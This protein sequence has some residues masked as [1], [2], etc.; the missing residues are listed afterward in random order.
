MDHAKVPNGKLTPQSQTVWDYLKTGRSLTNLIAFST[1]GVGSVSRRMTEV[2]RNAGVHAYLQ[3]SNQEITKTW[4][5]DGKG[6]LY[7]KYQVKERAS[8]GT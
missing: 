5:R 4:D 6:K 2:T 3:A 8:A 1:L 7:I